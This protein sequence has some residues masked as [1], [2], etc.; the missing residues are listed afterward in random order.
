METSNYSNPDVDGS[1]TRVLLL[2]FSVDQPCAFTFM[3]SSGWV[4]CLLV[5]WFPTCERL[6]FIRSF[7]L[8]LHLDGANFDLWI[9]GVTRNYFLDWSNWDCDH[10]C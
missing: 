2:T 5:K 7:R 4:F 1:N 9:N 10:L 3:R 6:V 8:T